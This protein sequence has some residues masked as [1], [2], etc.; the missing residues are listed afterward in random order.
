MLQFSSSLSTGIVAIYLEISEVTGKGDRLQ[1]SEHR[2]TY[3]W[4]L[5]VK[6]NVR[7]QIRVTVGLT[8]MRVV[9]VDDPLPPVV[10]DSVDDGL[11]VVRTHADGVVQEP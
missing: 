11:V 6:A 2:G 4:P 3:F 1:T 8:V 5:S 7:I 10:F 9:Q